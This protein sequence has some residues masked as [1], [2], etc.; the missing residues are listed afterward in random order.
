M[1][2]VPIFFMDSGK[3]PVEKKVNRQS[4]LHENLRERKIDPPE[5]KAEA[6]EPD[7][8][9]FILNLIYRSADY[10]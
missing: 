2:A 7:I 4:V 3:R 10:V 1:E 5:I 6:K 9:Q 8:P